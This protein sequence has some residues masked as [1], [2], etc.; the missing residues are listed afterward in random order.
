[1]LILLVFV[2]TGVPRHRRSTSLAILFVLNS[3]QTTFFAF[4]QY[5]HLRVASLLQHLLLV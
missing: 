2:R 1:M 3:F 4:T 5:S